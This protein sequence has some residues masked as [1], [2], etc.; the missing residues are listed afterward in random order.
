MRTSIGKSH[1]LRRAAY[2]ALAMLIAAP[3]AGQTPAF[4]E[5]SE[6]TAAWMLRKKK[7]ANGAQ[8]VAIKKNS[9]G[10]GVGAGKATTETEIVAGKNVWPMLSVDGAAQLQAAAARYERIVLDGGWP[11]VPKGTYKKGAEGKGVA[12]LNRRLYIEGYIRREA[13]EG[14]FASIYTSATVDAVSRFQRNHGLAVTGRVD[15]PTLAQLNV[16][17]EERLR[18]IRANLPRLA[19]YA[20][21]LGTRYL[22]VNVPAQQIET[23]SN[24]TVFSRH[25]AVVGRPERPTPVVM[26][27]VSDINF[28]PYWNAPPSIV[29]K[30]LIPRIRSGG[31][32]AMREMN[33]KVFK[34]FGGPEVDPGEIDWDSEIVDNYHFRQEPGPENAMATAKIN[35]PSPFGIYLHDT[36]EKHLLA[37]AGRFYSSGC[38]RVDKV[39]VLLNWI[40]NGQDGFDPNRIEYLAQSRERLDVKVANP[41]QI[42]VVYLTA[43][44]TPGGGPVAFRNDIYE[45][46][47]TGFV[48]GQPLPVGETQGGQRFV[49][50]PIPRLVAAVNDSYA[51]FSLFKRRPDAK[52]KLSAEDEK[53]VPVVD[54]AKKKPGTVT[55]KTAATV[56]T[57]KKPAEAKKKEKN[58]VGLFDWESYR[59]AQKAEGAAVKTKKA[60]KKADSNN[61]GEARK[62]LALALDTQKARKAPAQTGSKAPKGT[63]ASDCK[64]A[65]DGKLPKDCKPSAALKKIKAKPAGQSAEAN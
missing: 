52:K 44:P 15:G 23:V 56:K 49:L 10:K 55:V 54:S 47:G 14:E 18:T 4:A 25:N 13:T 3:L 19:E 41:P 28:N 36:P 59:K 38:V 20:K 6:E 2:L 60:E 7:K 64:P 35:F 17:A 32:K 63:A 22:V 26:T 50:K 9:V 12:A 45:L 57:V 48:V 43:W 61:K 31:S 16:S 30:D 46:D 24:G 34:G 11:T 1:G 29:E 51:G 39:A 33:I 40:L 42:R 37:T 8:P 21:N 62:K 5:M 27:A 58:Y 53:E 65:K